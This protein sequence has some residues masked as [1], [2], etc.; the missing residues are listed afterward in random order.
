MAHR[1]LVAVLMLPVLSAPAVASESGYELTP[2]LGVSFDTS[3]YEQIAPSYGLVLGLPMSDRAGLELL[4][5]R[6]RADARVVDATF[7]EPTYESAVNVDHLHFGG[8]YL[9]GER[10]KP[11]RGFV[12]VSVGVARVDPP[13][14]FEE[15]FSLS[16]A[17]G[18]GVQVRAGRRT[19]ARFQVSWIS[20]NAGS[21]SVSCSNGSCSI[22][23]ESVAA[24]IEL[25]AGLT[26]VF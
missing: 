13:Q 2:F 8:I 14:G 1:I 6:Q 7:V 18:G 20:T 12:N 23:S 26:V 22:T 15:S 4:L 16:F 3:A 21:G 5:S 19:R 10:R 9:G 25:S 24:G 17:A 11:S